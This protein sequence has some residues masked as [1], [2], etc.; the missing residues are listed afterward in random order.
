MSLNENLR[1]CKT[2]AGHTWQK[3]GKNSDR[4]LISKAGEDVQRGGVPVF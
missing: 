4:W 3:T 1:E 2:I